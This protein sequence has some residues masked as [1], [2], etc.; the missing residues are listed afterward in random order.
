MSRLGWWATCNFQ[1]RMGNHPRKDCFSAH[2]RKGSYVV[3]FALIDTHTHT[4][5]FPFLPTGPS[6]PFR[7][8]PGH[9]HVPTSTHTAPAGSLVYCQKS[10]MCGVERKDLFLQGT[11]VTFPLEHKIQGQRPQV[12]SSL[13]LQRK[14]SF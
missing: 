13:S 7:C 5:T 9:T 12:P 8:A 4:E 6:Q 3:Q 1:G 11:A 10:C 14:P 2:T